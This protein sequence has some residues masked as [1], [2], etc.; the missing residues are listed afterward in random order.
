MFCIISPGFGQRPTTK[1][2]KTYSEALL[3]EGYNVVTI[4]PNH[5]N[6]NA[7]NGSEYQLQLRQAVEKSDETGD[8]VL[9][10]Y[11]QGG[12]QVL[13][14]LLDTNGHKLLHSSRKIH[15]IL[16]DPYPPEENI[17]NEGKCYMNESTQ[18]KTCV[19]SRLEKS[20]L[21][22]VDGDTKGGDV[23]RFEIGKITGEEFGLKEDFIRILPTVRHR[24]VPYVALPVVIKWLQSLQT[25][26]PNKICL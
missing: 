25:K 16:L 5:K 20:L 17:V 1:W 22:S 13:E 8:L 23:E 26:P 4:D 3:N 19:L 14:F 2:I 15:L 10:G 7:V 12:C 9:I 24:K 21:F 6:S 18:A 11:S